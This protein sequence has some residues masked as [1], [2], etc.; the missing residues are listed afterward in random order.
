[1]LLNRSVTWAPCHEWASKVLLL[2]EVR[3]RPWARRGLCGGFYGG[4]LFTLAAPAQKGARHCK[5]LAKRRQ[6]PVP[7]KRPQAAGWP[8][9]RQGSR[10]PWHARVSARDVTTNGRGL[11]WQ[12]RPGVIWQI[13]GAQRSVCHTPLWQGWVSTASC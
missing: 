6:T 10:A 11:Q 1:M 3:G 9:A 8:G 13:E 7:S 5:Q 12:A 2:I 4:R